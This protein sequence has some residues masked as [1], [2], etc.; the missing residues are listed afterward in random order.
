[1]SYYAPADARLEIEA[2]PPTAPEEILL[3]SRDL[4]DGT[5]QTDLSVPGMRC[6][7]CIA[8]VEKTLAA[9]GGVANARVNLSTRRVAVRWYTVG[10]GAPDLIGALE[11]IGTRARFRSKPRQGSRTAASSQGLAVAGFCAELSCCRIRLFGADGVT[12]QAFHLVSAA[13]AF[14]PFIFR[15]DLLSLGVVGIAPRSHEHGRA[16]IGRCDASLQ[17]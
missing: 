1:M 15:K 5:R 17:P 7:G 12:R 2:A 10:G 3:A 6:G 8:A 9:L 13:L 4:G 14:L 16:D 11:R